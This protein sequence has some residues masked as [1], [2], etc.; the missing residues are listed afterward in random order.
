MSSFGLIPS[1]FELHPEALFLHKAVATMNLF[2]ADILVKCMICFKDELTF[3]NLV[4]LE[5]N[6][7]EIFLNEKYFSTKDDLILNLNSADPSLVA[8]FSKHFEDACVDMNNKMG[9]EYAKISHQAACKIQLL[10]YELTLQSLVDDIKRNGPYSSND[11]KNIIISQV[12]SYQ[13]LVNEGFKKWTIDST[14][15]NSLNKVQ[16]SL[17]EELFKTIEKENKNHSI[18]GEKKRKS[19]DL[20][21]GEIVNPKSNKKKSHSSA[22][23]QDSDIKTQREKALLYREE[24][25]KEKQGAKSNLSKEV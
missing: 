17:I 13:D 14:Q 10:L 7:V 19:S 20:D 6:H 11:L 3:N 9:L 23:V 4:G 5:L 1:T 2:V 18:P 12:K 21:H 25:L 24:L 15:L 22:T 16:V 8:N